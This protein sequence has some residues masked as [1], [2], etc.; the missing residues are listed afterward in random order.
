MIPVKQDAPLGSPWLAGI[1]I[2][3]TILYGIG[4]ISNLKSDLYIAFESFGVTLLMALTAIFSK[5]WV[6]LIDLWQLSHAYMPL[7]SSTEMKLL[8]Q[9][10]EEATQ[11]N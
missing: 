9:M 11:S 6:W 3:L 1:K 7:S 4:I 2:L 10:A 8:A 5:Q